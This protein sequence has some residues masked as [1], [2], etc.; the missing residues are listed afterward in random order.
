MEVG[1]LSCFA[2][3]SAQNLIRRP[4]SESFR[5]IGRLSYMWLFGPVLIICRYIFPIADV[6]IL[7]HSTESS[8]PPLL[9]V[10]SQASR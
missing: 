1:P 5:L 2:I 3:C 6:F 8:Y 4:E 9:V 10:I 7:A